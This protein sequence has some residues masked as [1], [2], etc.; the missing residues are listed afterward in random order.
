MVRRVAFHIHFVPAKVCCFV[1][2]FGI[3][4]KRISVFECVL[5]RVWKLRWIH[6]SFSLFNYLHLNFVRKQRKGNEMNQK[7]HRKWRCSLI[8]SV[9]VWN[10]CNTH[11]LT[12]KSSSQF[13]KMIGFHPAS[14]KV[15]VGGA[16]SGSPLIIMMRQILRW[17][18]K[19]TNTFYVEQR[20]KSIDRCNLIKLLRIV[21]SS[22]YCLV[23]FAL[24]S[25]MTMMMM[26]IKRRGRATFGWSQQCIDIVCASNFRSFLGSPL[27]YWSIPIDGSH[28][29]LVFIT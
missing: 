13:E 18:T 6:F 9:R 23:L 28:K 2:G 5:V 29:E 24:R 25:T 16:Y 14:K 1:T 12:I 3:I 8:Y 27:I 7:S 26:V 4:N 17:A 21:H 11:T 20:L 22:C 19:G 15:N 10:Y